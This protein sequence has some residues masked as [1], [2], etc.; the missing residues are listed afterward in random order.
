MYIETVHRI[1]YLRSLKV[2]C[3]VGNLRIRVRASHVSSTGQFTVAAFSVQL[4]ISG[5]E[6]LLVGAGFSV[7]IPICKY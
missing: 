2:A 7:D 4:A 6:T 3:E 1:I 5:S